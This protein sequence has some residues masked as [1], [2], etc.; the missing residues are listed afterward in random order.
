MNNGTYI[1]LCGGISHSLYTRNCQGAAFFDL[2]RPVLPQLAEKRAHV[3][4]GYVHLTGTLHDEYPARAYGVG[5][6]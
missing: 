2:E 3:S 6:L 5:G 4:G 1:K